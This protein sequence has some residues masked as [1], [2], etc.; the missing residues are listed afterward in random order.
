MNETTGGTDAARPLVGWVVDVQ[1]DFMLP[2]R[3]AL[4]ARPV[5]CVGRRGDRRSSD[6]IVAR[7]GLDADALRA[8]RLYR[9]LARLRG[10]RDRHRLPRPGAGHVPPALHGDS[11]D[12]DEREGA[13]ILGSVAP[14]E[15]RTLVLE[16]GAGDAEARALARQAVAER[17]PVFIHKFEFSVFEGAPADAFLAGLDEAFGA[18]PEFVACGVATDVCVRQAVEGFL[19]RHRPVRV[20]TDATWGLGLTP[21]EALFRAWA[22]RGA[23][24]TTTDAL[25][26]GVA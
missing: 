18:A 26:A 11:P 12:P 3:A 22:D 25:T 8:G 6:E 14:D 15:E 4:R 20:V 13:G 23:S 19:D 9:R 2:D 16:R 5:R 1:N 21:P 17:R 24:L 10:P 7:R